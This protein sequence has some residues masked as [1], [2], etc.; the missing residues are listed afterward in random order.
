[1]LERDKRHVRWNS[2]CDLQKTAWKMMNTLAE[3][4]TMPIAEAIQC[5]EWRAVQPS[6]TVSLPITSLLKIGR[7]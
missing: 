6:F 5:T 2:D 4:M 1:M 7:Y 3:Y